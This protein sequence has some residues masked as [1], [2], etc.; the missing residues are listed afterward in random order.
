[1]I[2]MENMRIHYANRFDRAGFTF[3]DLLMVVVVVGIVGIF[4]M[5]A[6]GKIEQLSSRRTMVRDMDKARLVVSVVQGA[7][8]G[9]VHIVDPSGSVKETLRRLSEGVVAESGMFA[10]QTFRVRNSET[11]IEVISRFLRIEQ[12][13]LVYVGS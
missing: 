7:E 4:V 12:G 1:M 9:G 6:F 3:N 8:T 10:G 5:P 2:I 13:L 11:D